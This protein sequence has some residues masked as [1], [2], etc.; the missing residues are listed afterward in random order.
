M[1]TMTMMVMMMMMPMTMTMPNLGVAEQRLPRVAQRFG[2]TPK[3]RREQPPQPRRV[4][5]G[6]LPLPPLRVVAVVGRRRERGDTRRVE[7]DRDDRAAH[8]ENRRSGSTGRMDIDWCHFMTYHD[9]MTDTA[10]ERA[11][12]ER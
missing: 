11:T 3:S 5:L 8:L 4:R 10:S 6:L 12:S 2:A 1:M 7:V 9:A